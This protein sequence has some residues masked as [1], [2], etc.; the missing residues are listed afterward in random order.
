MTGGRPE[1]EFVPEPEEPYRPAGPDPAPRR[2]PGRR[3]LGAAVAL[4]VAA[5]LAFAVTRPANRPRPT[6]APSGTTSTTGTSPGPT[7]SVASFAPPITAPTP[8]VC[9]AS[10][11]CVVS[12]RVPDAVQAAARQRIA[13]RE[14]Q[15][16]TEY[17]RALRSGDL[18]VV[19]RRILVV[20][21]HAKVAIDVRRLVGPAPDATPVAQG[22]V[23][24]HVRPPG[25]DVELLCYPHDGRA[26]AVSALRALA[27]D[28]RLESP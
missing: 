25:F 1:I 19:E 10:G 17:A 26:P 13:L 6:A 22:V 21:A 18:F 7:S 28:P 2:R 15:V 20:D 3:W 14:L 9:A 8:D 12:P 23:V 27:S 11:F 5:A 24:V 4:A 16:Q